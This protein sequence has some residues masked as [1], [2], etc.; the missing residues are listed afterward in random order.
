MREIGVV[1]FF[2]QFSHLREAFHLSLSFSETITQSARKRTKSLL[3]QLVTNETVNSPEQAFWF[4][5]CLTSSRQT[6]YLDNTI[7]ITV[8]FCGRELRGIRNCRLTGH[9]SAMKN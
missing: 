5:I 1:N 7:R 9:H 3:C 4:V 2:Y 8:V 6:P